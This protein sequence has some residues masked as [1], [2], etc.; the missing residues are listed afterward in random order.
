MASNGPWFSLRTLS[1]T[2]ATTGILS[3]C[4]APSAGEREKYMDLHYGKACAASTQASTGAKY[5]ACVA[6]AYKADRQR[7]LKQYNADT[8]HTGAAPLLLLH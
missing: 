2:V 4:A 3:A 6:S 1:I 7:A 8:G 5:D